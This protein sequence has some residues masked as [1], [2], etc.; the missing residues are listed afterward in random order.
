MNIKELAEAK[1]PRWFGISHPLGNLGETFHLLRS[2]LAKCDPTGDARRQQHYD[3]C[4]ANLLRFV[5]LSNQLLGSYYLRFQI[6]QAV[7]EDMH[8]CLPDDMLASRWNTIQKRFDQYNDK[9]KG[10]IKNWKNY[11]A[12]SETFDEPLP[13]SISNEVRYAMRDLNRFF[14][15]P[16]ELE[17]SRSETIYVRNCWLSLGLIALG[18]SIAAFGLI[19]LAPIGAVS[20]VGAAANHGVGGVGTTA[21]AGALGGTL[22]A[23]LRPAPVAAPLYGEPIFL[24]PILGG[25]AGLVLWL[26]GA[27]SVILVS[28]FVY[29]LI[30]MS[31]GFSDGFLAKFLSQASEKVSQRAVQAIGHD[32]R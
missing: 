6:L 11:K 12:C 5:Q 4:V 24:R 10:R 31:V 18:A 2:D 32:P 17:V 1:L 23:I 20:G 9:E 3:D 27:A 25:V 13:A 7:V 29:Y 30:A 22:S 21:L 8:M 15:E 28:P 26:L 14:A 19:H 16:V